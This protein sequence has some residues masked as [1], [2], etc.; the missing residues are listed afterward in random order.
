MGEFSPLHWLLVIA[1]ALIVFGPKRLP[2]IGKSLGESIQAFKKALKESSPGEPAAKIE[3][4]KSAL[5][6]IES[7]N[8]SQSEKTS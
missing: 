5:T 2:E 3:S 4:S 8:D 1:V 7:N 6:K